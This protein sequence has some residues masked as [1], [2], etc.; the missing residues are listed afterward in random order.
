MM[1]TQAWLSAI[2]GGIAIARDRL[3]V[4]D[5]KGDKYI[6]L[7]KRVGPVSRL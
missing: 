6:Y 7:G 4:D 5:T 3:G 2:D 1:T